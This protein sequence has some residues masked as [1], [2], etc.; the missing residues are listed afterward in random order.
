MKNDSLFTISSK[1]YSDTENSPE[2][3]RNTSSHN[4][5]SRKSSTEKDGY[6]IKYQKKKLSEPQLSNKI[7]I[8]TEKLNNYKLTNNKTFEDEISEDMTMVK[9]TLIKALYNINK[10]LNVKIDNK[11]QSKINLDLNAFII[12]QDE[13]SA[14]PT[15]PYSKRMSKKI[16]INEVLGNINN[17]EVTNFSNFIAKDLKAENDIINNKHSETTEYRIRKVSDKDTNVNPT[18][19]NNINSSQEFLEREENFWVENK[20]NEKENSLN[21]QDNEIKKEILNLLFNEK[22]LCTSQ[23]NDLISNKIDFSNLLNFIATLVNKQNEQEYLI[24]KLKSDIENLELNKPNGEYI[25]LYSESQQMLKN[26]Q[27]YIQEIEHENSYLKSKINDFLTERRKKTKLLKDQI[28]D[29]EKI[30]NKLSINFN[31]EN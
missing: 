23:K 7:E 4:Q 22:V 11:D 19:R 6:V 2:K 8:K 12:N 3:P 30:L 31:E 13:V 29:H 28:L 26:Q 5:K 1:D 10:E 9:G 20:N 27:I 21:Q 16:D 18:S 14:K 17:Q 24:N 25:K 15:D